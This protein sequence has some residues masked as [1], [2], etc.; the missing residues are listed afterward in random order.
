MIA[1]IIGAGVFGLPMLFAQLGF[2]PATG[3]FVTTVALVAVTH[4]FFVTL[5]LDVPE[6]MRIPGHAYRLLGNVGGLVATVSYPL[7]IIGSNI[8]YI[9][10]GGVFLRMLTHEAGFEFVDGIRWWQFA[11]VACVALTVFIGLRAVAKVE[12]VITWGLIGTMLALS[13]V[14]CV[15]SSIAE[16]SSFATR[17]NPSILP[18]GV[19]L[20][21][22]SGI[23]AIGEAVDEVGRKKRAS[24][25]SVVW[26]TVIAGALSYL[27]ALTFGA[28][29]SAT[30]NDPILELGL[31]VPRAVRWLIPLAGFLAVITSSIATAQDLKA[32]M[33]LDY[34]VPKHVAWIVAIVVPYAFALMITPDILKVMGFFGAVFVGLNGILL[35]LMVMRVYKKQKKKNRWKTTIL[36]TLVCV[37]FAIGILQKLFH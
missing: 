5:A 10:L 19:F 35:S 34:R 32:T 28:I 26:G 4:A 25:T 31:H 30:A 3:L 29:V 27:F 13:V 2:W 12:S 21:S 6:K 14:A 8:A 16:V 15:K 22:M 18:F 24:Y 23:S 11:F 1:T 36:P 33:H 9:L 7:Q 17:F 20:F 37:A